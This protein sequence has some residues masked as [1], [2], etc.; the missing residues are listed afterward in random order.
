[1]GFGGGRRGGCGLDGE[2]DAVGEGVVGLVGWS[3]EEARNGWDEEDEDD[4]RGGS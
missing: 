4:G 3:K 2:T 1:M